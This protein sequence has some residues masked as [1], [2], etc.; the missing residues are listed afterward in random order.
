MASPIKAYVE[1]RDPLYGRVDMTSVQHV[2][3]S[4][5]MQRSARIKQLG[6]IYLVFT[7]A[8]HS[9]LTHMIGS[10]HV[11]SI[12]AEWLLKRGQITKEEAQNVKLTSLVHDCG[13][14]IFSHLIEAIRGSHDTAGIEIIQTDLAPSIYKDGGDPDV[15][16]RLMQRKDPLSELV[17]S[18]PHGGEKL[19]YL[20]R[21]AYFALGERL[22]LD[23]LFTTHVRWTREHGLCVLPRGLPL[24]ASTIDRYWYQ[25]TELYERI[26]TRLAQ[27]YLQELLRQMI[28]LD[29]IVSQ[30]LQRGGEDGV[31]GTIGYLCET[32]G[33][34]CA[35]RNER[36]LLRT[37]PKKTLVYSPFPDR[38]PVRDKPTVRKLLCSSELISA[39][40]QWPVDHIARLE[41]GIAHLLGI[42]PTQVSVAPSP[43]ARRW[44]VPDV[45]VQE[46][47]EVR[48]L[49]EIMP[50]LTIASWRYCKMSQNIVIGVTNEHR[51]R[52]VSSLELQEKIHDLLHYR[53]L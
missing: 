5:P 20:V 11:G 40:E 14:D 31:M 32:Q 46:E 52:L 35:E 53:E 18:T 28:D 15:I 1:I 41:Q 50:E 7:A 39:S 38:V 12:R 3:H 45:K 48:P 16:V 4:A 34:P 29:P 47:G 13:H 42:P 10:C 9:R 21:D 22:S 26:S 49:V 37:Y 51:E 23:D 44:R 43:P 25:Y 27:R 17:F 30:R 24:I 36:I 33:L 6:G 2:L 8:S 19:D